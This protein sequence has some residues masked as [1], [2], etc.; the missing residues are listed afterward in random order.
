MKSLYTQ[1][2]FD[3]AKTK[4]KLPCECSICNNVFYKS[5]KQINELLKGRKNYS[6]K[7]CSKICQNKSQ[8]TSI[9]YR[10][11]TSRRRSS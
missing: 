2:Q 6:A 11:Y 1:E 9:K 10:I 7:Y 8:T 3:N 4:D 5:K